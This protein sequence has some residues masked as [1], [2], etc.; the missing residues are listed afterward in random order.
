MLPRRPLSRLRDP[1]VDEHVLGRQPLVGVLAE[2]AAD[3]A[4]R[5]RRN[6]VGKTEL[7]ATNLGEQALVLLAVERI[8]ERGKMISFFV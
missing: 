2:E 4:A 7:P 6:R 1:R 8:S 5:A 3:E